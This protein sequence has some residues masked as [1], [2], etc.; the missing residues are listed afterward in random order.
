MIN[1]NRKIGLLGLILLLTFSDI[2]AQ[3][4]AQAKAILAG[5]SKK[6]R[7]YDMVKADFSYGIKNPQAKI[8]ETQNG[9]LYIKSKLNKYKVSVGTQELISDGKVQWTYLKNDNEV[10]VSEIDNSASAL[11]PAQI[12]TIYE[13]GFK[14]VYLG[15]T[16]LNNRVYQNIE[17]APLAERSFSKIKLRIDKVNKQISNIVVYDK[18]GNVYTYLIKTFT[19]NVKVSESMF[20]FDAKKYPGVDVVDLR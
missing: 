1:K 14:S 11:N 8:N 3:T 16:K 5:V 7:S 12:F 4:D 17:L 20:S 6:Y 18:N 15:E 13:K 9:T 10:Q 19:P 2:Y